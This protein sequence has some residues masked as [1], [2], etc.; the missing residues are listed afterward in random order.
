MEDTFYWLICK[1]RGNDTG[2][3]KEHAL[4]V[5]HVPVLVAN[6]QHKKQRHLCTGMM[7]RFL[8]RWLLLAWERG[9][10]GSREQKKGSGASRFLA[11]SLEAL[12]EHS[13]LSPGQTNSPS[14]NK[15]TQPSIDHLFPSG[16]GGQG[17]NPAIFLSFCCQ[18]KKRLFL[19]VGKEKHGGGKSRSSR[20]VGL[21]LRL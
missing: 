8:R 16:V 7:L 12:P 4:K 19:S 5:S 10:H 18:M 15:L 9:Y 6:C 14:L 2:G 20:S 11:S 3:K 17:F 1:V 13:G 21:R